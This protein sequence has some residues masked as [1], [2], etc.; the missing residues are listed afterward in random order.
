MV[1]DQTKALIT[2]GGQAQVVTLALD[3]LL[4]HQGPIHQVIVLHPDPANPRVQR[5]LSQLIAEFAGGLYRQSVP[6]SFHHLTLEAHGQPLEAVTSEDEAEAM[7]QLASDLLRELKQEQ[8]RLHLCI[9]GGPRLVALMLTSA[10]LLH[11]D[12]RDRLWHLYTPPEFLAQAREGAIL[13]APP[14]VDVR[15][16]PVPIVPWGTY[17][18]QLRQLAQPPTPTSSA[19]EAVDTATQRNCAAVWQS[20]SDRER[21]VLRLLA[22]GATPQEVANTLSITLKTVDTYKTK[23]LSQCRLIW[24][25]SE[26]EH[27]TYHFLHDTFGPWLKRMG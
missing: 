20:L 19:P 15:L 25:L 27:L 17:F 5:A 13:H 24:E 14:E 26:D 10:A 22:S 9:A 7:W 16:I 21:E 6:I 8:Q 18:P 1:T 3:W 12:H 2:M 23:I 11:C 4:A